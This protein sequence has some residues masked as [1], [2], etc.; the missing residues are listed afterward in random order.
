M[1]K[2]TCLT[3]F[4]LFCSSAYAQGV[5]ILVQRY[6]DGRTGQNLA[7][8]ALTVSNVN[9]AAFGKVYTLPVDGWV[10]AQPLYKSN[11]F[12][13]GKGTFNVLFI[14]TE[15]NSVYAFDADTATPLWQTSFINPAGGVTTQPSGTFATQ[16]ILSE[17]GITSTPVID[18]ATNTM[19]VVAKTIEGGASTSIFR[20]HALDIRTGVD[21]VP[22]AL[23]QASVPGTGAGSSGGVLSFDATN[24]FQR[25]GLLRANGI[26]YVA[27]GGSADMPPY[28][29]WLL[30][31]N[32]A[33]LAQVAAFCVAPNGLGGGI[34]TPSEAPPV[35]SSGN[36]YVNT[37]NG[38]FNGSA[39]F[40][41]SFIKLSP[42]LSLLDYFAPFN[43]A[44]VSSADLDIAAAGF[45]L[46]P[47]SAG[48]TAH[49][50]ILVGGGKDGTIYVL[51]RDH[52]G[53]FNGSYTNPDSQIIQEIWNQIGG[54][55]TN[56]KGQT[57]S[58]VQNNYTT[59]AFWQNHLYWCG[60]DD[61]CK[62][63]NLSN[64][65]LTTTPVSQASTVFPFAGGQPVI[66]ASSASATNAIL[67]VMENGSSSGVLHAYNATN[68]ASELY[69][70]NQAPNNRDTAGQGVKFVI[71]TVTNGKVFVG[72]Q[73]QVDAY[74]LLASTPARLPAP[75]FNPAQGIYNNAIQVSIG[76]SNSSAA[77]YYT[78]DGS[79]PTTS[80]A[81]YSGP[82][83]V[84]NTT[85]IRAI[86]VLS[87]FLTSPVASGTFTIGALPA[88]GG[89]VQ[90][91]YASPQGD[92]PSVTVP[93]TAPQV[94]GDLNV[95]VV[96]WNDSTATIIDVRDTMNNSY[97]PAVGPTVRSGFGSQAIYYAKSIVSAAANANSVTVTFTGVGAHHPDIRIAE[98]N[99]L[100]PASPLDAIA[101]GQ[102]DGINTD[103]GLSAATTQPTELIV[104]ANLVKTITTGPG[105]GFINR[106]ITVPDGDIL[107][108]KVVT[109]A[110]SYNASAPVTP[111]GEWIMQMVTF[112]VASSLDNSPPTAPSNLS[113]TPLAPNRIGLS[114]TAS[115][116]NVGVTAY[117]I[118]RC[119]GANCASFAQLTTV[120]GITYTDTRTYPFLTSETYRVY[121]RDAA[122]N[123]SPY[124]NTATA[125]A[126]PD[127]T[128]PT[129]PTNLTATPIS[130]S[131]INL[132][133]GASTDDVGVTAYTVERCQGSGCANF[134]QIASPAGTS[135]SDTGLSATTSYTYRVWAVD[136][137]GNVSG[138]SNTAAAT[139]LAG[140]P[141][142]PQ[143]LT[144]VQQVAKNAGTGIS[145][146]TQTFPA[147]STSGNLIV[148]SV[149]WGGQN[150]SVLSVTD[151]KA[152]NYQSAVGPTNWSGTAKRAQ[153]FYAKN[154]VGGGAPITINVTLSGNA[155]SVLLVYQLEY[156]G[157]DKNAPVDVAT[158]AIG[159]VTTVN[160]GAIGTNF[161]N[162]LIYGFSASDT[163]TLSPGSGFAA[164]SRFLGNL[165]EDRMVNVTGS[166]SASATNSAASNWVMQ[167]VAFKAVAP[168]SPTAP[169]NLSAT[170]A[171]PDTVN[172]S[173]TAATETG[174]T[175]SQYLIERCIGAGCNNFAQ[176]GITSGVTY[177]DTGT[178]G[179]TTYVYRVRAQDTASNTG[180][181][182]ST[183]TA[184][185][186]SPTFTAPSNLLATASSPVQINLSWTA[187]TETGGTISQYL[188]ER[189]V[190]V[191]CA[192][193]PSNFAQ[194]GTAAT[195]TF[196]DTGL[197]GSTSYSYRVRATDALS[198]FSAYSNTASATTGAP[199][200]TAPSN[201]TATAAGSTQINLIWTA[202]TETGGTITQY[203]IERCQGVNCGNTPSNF[204]QVNT[205]AATSFSDNGLTAS[206][207]YSYRVR[208][209]DASNNLGPYSNISSATTS[210]T[211]PTAPANLAAT[212]AGP[213]QIN[214]SWGAS[215]ES[216][217]TISQYLIERCTGVNCANT[218]S[219][220]AQ[221]GTSAGLSFNNTGLLGS[222]SYSYRVRAQDTSNNNGPYSN[223]AVAV[224]TAPTFT[225]PSN[226]AAASSGPAQINLSWTAGT[227]SGGALSQYL[228]ERCLGA[229]CSNFA[230]V[231]TSATTT[232][233]D[234]AGLLGSTTYSY[235]VRA[236]DAANN[237][238][239]Y[240]NTS[241]ATT[242]PPTFT[243]PTNLVATPVGST[244]INLSWTAATEAGGTI[245]Q[246]LVESCQGSGCSNF[247]QIGTSTS[248]AFSNTG[249][250]TGTT[251]S[252]RVRATDAVNNLGPYSNVAGATTTVVQPPI[253]F[254]QSNYASPQSPQTLVSVTY[255]AAQIA[256]DLN[257]V[258]VGWNDATAT[259]TGV[260]DTMGNQYTP[261][262]LPTV[263]AGTASQVIYYAK[264][265]A[266]A[267][268]GTNQVKVTFSIAAV[269]PDIRILEYGGID[270]VSPLDVAVGAQGSTASSSSG[271]VT[272][273]NANDLIIGANLVQ[274]LTTGAGSGFTSRM[275]TSPD[276]DI[277]EDR[278]VTATGSYTATAPVSPSGKWI[279][280]LVSFK[281]HP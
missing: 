256:G 158:A 107:E 57:L 92:F 133:W 131:Q 174:G 129:A 29:G 161:A 262:L 116:D 263:Q 135:Y 11:L 227:E 102:G 163:G 117:V 146:T 5:D 220:F 142:P 23:I 15:H 39:N 98:Y 184:V 273:T 13:P 183:A 247:A 25:P 27:F 69:N 140:P 266:A 145:S 272:T 219:N 162:D 16:D 103:S 164:E 178:L 1:K 47:D 236:T 130:N 52:M 119:S 168:V 9:T 12:I 240:S 170:A 137:S 123:V 41:D 132:S 90:G 105:P 277:V 77:I 10:Y 150:I 255:T 118:E 194:V 206:T 2:L 276:G 238:S 56:P 212:P 82:I 253:T 60:A 257:V 193:T 78:L 223:T 14:A 175:I 87:G 115:T 17:V 250:L 226:L 244:Q 258:A 246:Y 83:A 281:R 233:S 216:G 180:P 112:K 93:F 187:S 54:V 141:P 108:D 111:S 169:T 99:G 88:T 96:G 185:T 249:L 199:T 248:T 64:G 114:W 136:A 36:I 225:P 204:A 156:S 217:G 195:T 245:S 198:N 205:S 106:M 148:V 91:N 173:W 279:M 203:L 241:S 31:Y 177:S 167:M 42:G 181:Y 38:D 237:L 210:V 79:I 20:I 259:V 8:T 26:V 189:C 232:Y 229:A 4:L 243:A 62:M 215:T 120:V 214:L 190:G 76:D 143:A 278:V 197:L 104:G 70:S 208:A 152:N 139:T 121:A 235:R 125:T 188:I 48:T 43:Q 85:T 89:F 63:F 251:Y 231:G 24:Q 267:A 7:E 126:P 191:N 19:Y 138:Y 186:A 109:V 209:T 252:Y 239:A 73:F 59:P 155:A 280:Q 110:G 207:S 71:P 159:A 171:G 149:K 157:A 242:A 46:L 101:A 113:A 21:K 72:A 51:D 22:P 144:F 81:I 32:P 95:A 274:T 254:I 55:R 40:G 213:V 30:A 3:A 122:G 66:T 201:L 86:A 61:R 234:T 221:I 53:N 33:T 172:L 270:T 35:D 44:A 28:N 65:L 176:V 264:N 154:I 127:T 50:H 6:D 230:Q 45:I 179:S 265:I 151:S 147:A 260:T 200:F 94:A 74:G 80:S 224:T 49:P 269:F 166:Y 37:G 134:A 271:A 268:A 97:L 261:A 75:V 153:T 182:S 100:D 67:W 34:W 222:T 275:I 160:S 202:A 218:P 165:V 84:V 211:S 128:P 228:V 124:S 192:S 58:Y 18:P 68:L 196:N